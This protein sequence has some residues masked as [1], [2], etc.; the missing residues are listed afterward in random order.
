MW[1]QYTIWPQEGATALLGLY[2][3]N[4]WILVICETT[5]WTVW[6]CLTVS[7]LTIQEGAEAGDSP[8]DEL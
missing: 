2:F 7:P 8:R 3:T 5:L 1:L 4:C 6:T